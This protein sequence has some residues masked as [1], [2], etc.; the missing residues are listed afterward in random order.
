MF[1]PTCEVL[2]KIIKDG[3]GPIK[4]DADLT[5][6]SITTFEFIFVLHLEQEIMEITDLLCKALQRQ[7]QDICNALRLVASTKLLLQKMK[8]E[9]WDGFLSLVMSFCQ[10]RNI[11]IPDMTSP[12]FTRGT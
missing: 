4:G 1:S 12:Y 11:D 3:T 8:D 10:E 2:L 5:Y 6:E 9:R 7:S